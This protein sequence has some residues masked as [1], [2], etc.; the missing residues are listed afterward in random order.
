MPS[1]QPAFFLQN[2]RKRLKTKVLAYKVPRKSFENLN[3]DGGENSQILKD[4]NAMRHLL[5]VTKCFLYMQLEFT[6]IYNNFTK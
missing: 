4:N 6:A 1:H 2:A 5:P 3:V